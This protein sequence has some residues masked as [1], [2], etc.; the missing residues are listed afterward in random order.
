MSR[1]VFVSLWACGLGIVVAIPVQSAPAPKEK[2]TPLPATTPALFQKSTNNLKIIGL[3]MHNFNDAVGNMPSNFQTKDGKPGL[4]W[5]VA[6]LPFLEEDKLYR[7][8]KLDEPWDSE[9][10]SKLIEKMPKV[11]TPV[12][13]R[14]EKGQTFYQ[15][16][17]GERTMLDPKGMLT[18][19]SVTDGL[20]NTFMVAEGGKPVV[21][22]KPDDLPFDGTK[23]PELGGMFDGQFN[24]LMGDGSVMRFPKGVDADVLRRGIDR[25][26]GEVVDFDDAI[27]KAK[28]KE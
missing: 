24:M 27:K 17:A 6:I 28:E 16:F 26:D 14:A 8:F 15:M 4:S 21:W 25:A 18:L 7:E 10:N 9:H 11:Y 5:R 23:I 1:R 13:G 22:T 2:E 12:R 3:A 20:S 19:A